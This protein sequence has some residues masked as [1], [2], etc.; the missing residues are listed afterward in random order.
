MWTE[1]G[2]PTSCRF[3]RASF[4]PGSSS[5]VVWRFPGQPVRELLCRRTNSNLDE[6][7]EGEIINLTPDTHTRSGVTVLLVT[8]GRPIS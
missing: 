3:T 7:S 4:R 6:Q 8:H 5:G 2:W 1:V